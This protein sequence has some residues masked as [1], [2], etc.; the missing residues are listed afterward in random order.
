MD[1]RPYRRVGLLRYKIPPN[2]HYRAHSVIPAQAG[3]QGRRGRS[4]AT[5]PFLH[6]PISHGVGRRTAEVVA[7]EMGTDMERFPAPGHLASWAGVCPG[8]RRSGE[9]RRRS[10]VRKGNNWLKPA[11]VFTRAG[12][13]GG[14]QGRRTDQDLSGS[15]IPAPRPAHWG[16]AGGGA[17]E[18]ANKLVVEA[19]LKAPGMNWAGEHVDPMAAL[20]TV[21]CSGRW[22]EVWPQINQ[23]LGE[24][25]REQAVGRQAKPSPQ[26]SAVAKEACRANTGPAAR[27][28][29]ELTP[30]SFGENHEQNRKPSA[31]TERR[32]TAPGAV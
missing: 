13:G 6:T 4:V 25:A 23:R 30:Q 9:K 32:P 20:R 22:G 29:A 14:G 16:Q 19:R 11:P 17:V 12:F 15:P 1:L 27:S 18:S 2:P 28:S 3:I 24:K 8:N 26:E 10:P 5:I 21:V 31:A 7:A